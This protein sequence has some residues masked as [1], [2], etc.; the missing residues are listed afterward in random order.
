MLGLAVLYLYQDFV[1]VAA[2]DQ[3]LQFVDDGDYFHVVRDN[4]E[5]GVVSVT[6]DTTVNQSPDCFSSSCYY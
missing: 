1:D 2:N 3:L 5:A 4:D 6:H